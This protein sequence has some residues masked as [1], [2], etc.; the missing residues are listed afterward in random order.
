M[1]FGECVGIVV[2]PSRAK[3]FQPS[4]LPEGQPSRQPLMVVSPRG[5]LM[6]LSW[7]WAMGYG[8]KNPVAFETAYDKRKT[9]QQL[10]LV[11]VEDVLTCFDLILPMDLRL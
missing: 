7:L 2:V 4:W 10:W 5:F 8:F 11:G 6:F 3:Y 9:N 1:F